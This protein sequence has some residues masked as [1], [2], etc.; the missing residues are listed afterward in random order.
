M[1]VWTELIKTAVIGT[2]RQALNLQPASSAL[3]E[4]LARLSNEDREG[5]L[6]S[7]AAAVSLY[8][9]AGRLP[10]K[11]AMPLPATCVADEM[12]SCSQRAAALH[13]RLMLEGQHAE[14]LAEW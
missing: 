2:E 10:V 3:A 5:A 4:L 11:D 8:E 12:P 7:A 14:L 6:L 9:R 1:D 13:L